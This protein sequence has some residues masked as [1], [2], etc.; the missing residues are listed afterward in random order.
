MKITT[1]TLLIFTILSVSHAGP[2]PAGGGAK[3]SL[4]PLA[5][6]VK[7]EVEAYDGEC[8]VT[9]HKTSTHGICV[10]RDRSPPASQVNSKQSKIDLRWGCDPAWPCRENENPCKI[11][12]YINHS[13]DNTIWNARCY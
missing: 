4:P 1:F 11:R 9:D 8:L 6:A 10:A 12:K 2:P 5:D 13:N 7:Q 3:P